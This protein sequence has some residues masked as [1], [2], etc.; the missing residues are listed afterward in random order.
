MRDAA[1]E[2]LHH[3]PELHL[4]VNNGGMMTGKPELSIDG[5]E[6]MFATNH[7]GPFLLTR[8][9]L[10]RIRQSTPARIVNVASSYHTYGKL[11]LDDV[12][13][14]ESFAPMQTYSRSKLGNVLF[15]LA[16]ARRLDGEELTVNCLHPGAVGSNIIP[17]NKLWLRLGGPIA[18][19]FMMSETRGART[20]IHLALSDDGRYFIVD[21]HR[22]QTISI[23]SVETGRFLKLCDSRTRQGKPQYTHAHPYL[24]PDNRHVIFNSNVTGVTQVYAATVPDPFLEQLAPLKEKEPDKQP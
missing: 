23:G 2:F 1:Q 24:T 6:I 21:N 9:L 17:T 3:H 12:H 11:D 18:R 16:L 19:P 15:T 20:S 22:T 8:L 7:L 14:L 10:E 13:T 4:L 5:I